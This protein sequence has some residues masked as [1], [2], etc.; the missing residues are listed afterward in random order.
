MKA[1][2][3]ASPLDKARIQRALRHQNVQTLPMVLQEIDRGS[4]VVLQGPESTSTIAVRGD[5][6]VICQMAG[7]MADVDD[8]FHT[9]KQIAKELGLKY[10]A[11]KGR[12]G[13]TRVLKKYG[14]KLINNE[15][16]RCPLT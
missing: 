14:F 11:L 13:W 3:Q 16:L 5:M 10:I 2:R 4:Y 12:K 9:C 15:V 1:V 7:I 6:L 8:I